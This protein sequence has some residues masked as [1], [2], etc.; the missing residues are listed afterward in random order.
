V[1][2]DEGVEELPREIVRS[3][4]VDLVVI[5]LRLAASGSLR[6]EG[7]VDLDETSGAIEFEA[8][9]AVLRDWSGRDA[10]LVYGQPQILD[11]VDVEV[12]ASSDSRGGEPCEHDKVDVTG[13]Q[14]LDVLGIFGIGT[15][16]G[17]A[18]G[19]HLT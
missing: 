16:R 9:A 4:P 15:A 1:A 2:V 6:F 12:R 8:K 11:L 18:A 10:K 13:K 17:V 14:D 19:I 5:A 3:L 7:A